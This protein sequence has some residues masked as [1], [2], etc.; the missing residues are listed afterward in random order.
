MYKVLLGC[1]L[2]LQTCKGQENN[3]TAN[4]LTD[5]KKEE[6]PTM[7]D[8]NVFDIHY[9]MGKFDP[10]SHPDF[11]EIPEKYADRKGRYLRKDVYTQFKKMYEAAYKDGVYLKIISSTRN[12]ENQKSIWEKKWGGITILED[13]TK[14]TTIK[15]PLPRALKILRYSS[16]PGTSRHHWGTDIDLNNLTNEF[17][18]D[19]EG[20]KIYDWLSLNAHLYGFCQVYSAKGKERPEGY[21]EEKWHW[22]YMPI[23]SQLV[24]IAKSFL[25]NEDIKGFEGHETAVEIDMLKKYV[26]SINPS[27]M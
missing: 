7:V 9:V 1:V 11:L 22:S 5:Q 25:K 14:A 16:M 17:F 15:K 23:S 20:K 27:C 8:T 3:S 13:G 6:V 19:G 10:A 12:F 2:I 4:N 18:A 26:L 24:Q 21:N